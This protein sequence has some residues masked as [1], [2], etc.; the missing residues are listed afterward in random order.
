MNFQVSA[1]SNLRTRTDAMSFG[2]KFPRFTPCF[3]PGTGMSGSQCVTQ[4]QFLQ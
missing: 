4:P 1:P 3:A 2:S